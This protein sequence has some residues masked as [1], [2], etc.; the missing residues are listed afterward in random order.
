M[1]DGYDGFIK[2]QT[3]K[4]TQNRQRLLAVDETSDHS[5]CFCALRTPLFK[6][7]CL[8]YH[9]HCTPPDEGCVTQ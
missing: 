9:L 2:T 1:G 6:E 3:K 7:I 4:T 5:G 8:L